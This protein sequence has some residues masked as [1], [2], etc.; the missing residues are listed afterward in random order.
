MLQSYIVVEH[1]IKR[2][3]KLN[4]MKSKLIETSCFLIAIFCY[5]N[6]S[7]CYL[8]G[9]QRAIFDYWIYKLGNVHT[10][11]NFFST[12]TVWNNF[13]HLGSYAQSM[14]RNIVHVCLH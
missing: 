11:K 12:T 5:N 13:Q 1:Y 8:E 3:K 2:M 9:V 14:L 6:E 4:A 10:Q 7:I